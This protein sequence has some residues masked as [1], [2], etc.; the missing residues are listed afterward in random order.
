MLFINSQLTRLK[1]NIQSSSADKCENHY[2]FDKLKY[3]PMLFQDKKSLVPLLDR[4][5]GQRNNKCIVY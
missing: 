2:I 5:L 1:G 3:S 4:P